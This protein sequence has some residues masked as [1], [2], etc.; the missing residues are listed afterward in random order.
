MKREIPTN[1]AEQMSVAQDTAK[2]S[3]DVLMW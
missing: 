1:I 3:W 2:L